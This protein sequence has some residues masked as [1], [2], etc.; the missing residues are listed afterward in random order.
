M[1][2]FSIVIPTRN[3][4]QLLAE[5]VRSVV[6]Q[7]FSSFELIVVDDNGSVPLLV[8]EDDQRVRVVRNSTGLGAAASRN[9][10]MRLSKGDWIV[11]LDDDDGWYPRRLEAI[12][13][14]IRSTPALRIVA[15]DVDII[16]NGEIVGRW[17]D[18]H[19]FPIANQFEG[20]LRSNFLFSSVAVKAQTL[21]SADGFDEALQLRED[22]ECWLRLVRL[23]DVAGLVPEVLAYHRQG[24]GKA[25][26]DRPAALRVGIDVLRRCLEWDLTVDERVAAIDHIRRLEAREEMHMAYH[27]LD[28]PRASRRRLCKVALSQ[29][30]P[31]KV[32]LSA[33]L[34]CF[35]PRLRRF[36]RGG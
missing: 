7:T 18:V 12:Y 32:R 27:C 15:T 29:N 6:S 8:D 28:S 5:A 10:G 30:L 14:C 2:F 9:V 33:G 36:V 24:Q 1:P 17:Y 3:R 22:Y 21:I 23:G 35:S 19:E 34:A 13:A 31:L 11:F 25:S 20:L 26:V 4:P 16:A